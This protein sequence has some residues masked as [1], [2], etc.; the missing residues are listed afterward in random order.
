MNDPRPAT[1]T[2]E[3][4]PPDAADPGDFA[5]QYQI[6]YPRLTLIAASITGDRWQ[7]EDIVQEAAMI[8]VE[9][10]DCFVP[11]SSVAAWLAEIVRRCALNYRRKSRGRKTYAADPSHFSQLADRAGAA[12]PAPIAATTGE[13][14]ADQRSFDDEVLHA[15]E[16]LSDSARCCL[17]LREVQ[18]L[19]YA[20]IA[21]LLH[22]PE[23][24]AMSHVHR[25]KEALRQKLSTTLS[26]YAQPINPQT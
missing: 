5:A 23:G 6:A 4:R 22:I 16:A 25:S 17:L 18:K 24:T 8:A 3:G 13:L 14:L 15:L 11:G 19:S 12:E 9:K 7:A 26:K 1:R 10:A 21:E 2:G 20:E